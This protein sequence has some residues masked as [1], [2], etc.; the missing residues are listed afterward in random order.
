MKA[1]RREM[2]LAGAA[3]LGGCVSPGPAW[4]VPPTPDPVVQLDSGRASGLHFRSTGGDAVRQFLGI[5]YGADTGP[6]RFLP[7]QPVAPWTGVFNVA[8]YGPACPQGA[9]GADQ[10]ESCLV[11]NVWAPEHRAN[12]KRPVL[13]YIHGGGYTSG[14]GASPL[15]HGANLAARGDVVVVTLNHRLNLFGHLH[16]GSISGADYAASGNAGLLDLVL[17]LEWVRANAEAFGGDPDCVTL[18]GQSGGGAK[19][20]CLM[21][22]PAAKGLFHRVW[23]MSGQQVTVQGPRGATARAKAAMEHLGVGVDA[24]RTMSVSTLLTA[25]Q[26]KDPSIAGSRIYWGPVLDEALPVHPFW[27]EAPELSRDIPMVMGN[28]REETGSLI[29]RGDPSIFELTW[30]TLPAR[31]ERDMVSD[32]DVHAAIAMYRRLYPA[33]PPAQVFIRAT[34]A[35]RSWRAQVIEAEARARQGAPTWVYQLDYPSRG[36]G[37]RYGAYHML[38]IPLVFANTAAEGADTGDDEAARTMAAAMSDALLRFARTGD[39][40]G[41]ALPAWPQHE[42]ARRETMMFDVATRVESDPRGEERRFFGRAP[43]IQ[44]GTY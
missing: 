24:L 41:G 37:G 40:N 38:D 3:A 23:T 29:A 17:A 21:A 15:T 19:I 27:P 2:L 9:G 42:L 14:N 18:F 33:L 10:G 35:G 39:P 13:V 34:S 43:Y 6:R 32:V 31:L 26:A 7:P 5:P 12:A 11:L 36:E 16:L 44:P 1:N 8:T 20:A 4:A 22:M 28:T 25:L 30:D